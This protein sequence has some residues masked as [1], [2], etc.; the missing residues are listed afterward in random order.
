M[1]SAGV[2]TWTYCSGVP[3]HG[4][5]HTEDLEGICNGLSRV[6]RTER[7]GVGFSSYLLRLH[8]L[9]LLSIK[10]QNKRANVSSFQFFETGV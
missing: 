5:V 8:M 2:N 9:S 6:L 7:A 1:A 4:H 3:K 10:E